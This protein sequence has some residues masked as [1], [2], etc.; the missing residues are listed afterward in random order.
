MLFFDNILVMLPTTCVFHSMSPLF[1]VICR[2]AAFSSV[3]MTTVR[4]S[5]QQNFPVQIVK[6]HCRS[7]VIQ[8]R[9]MSV[10]FAKSVDGSVAMITDVNNLF[11]RPVCLQCFA[12]VFLL[13]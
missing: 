1:C 9:V 12:N 2:H 10:R 8:T 11:A 13:S 4:F 5:V 7:R 6:R 3:V